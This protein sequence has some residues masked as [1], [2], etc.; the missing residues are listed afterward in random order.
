MPPAHGNLQKYTSPNPLQRYLLRRFLGRVG[1]VV[2]SLG[3]QAVLDAGCGEGFVLRELAGPSLHGLDLS[4]DALRLAREQAPRARL[5]AAHLYHLP[6]PDQAFPLVLC[7]EVLEHLFQP[8]Q[9]V[10]ELRRVTSGYLVASVPHEPWF[11]L[12][13]LLRAKNVTRWGSDP[14][15]LQHW[16]SGGFRRLLE[17]AFC[18]AEVQPVF[19]WLLG[20]A[21]K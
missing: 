5:V 18:R 15:H 7:L 8:E 16:G 12:A 14:E 2:G 1:A 9:A 13:N 19:P 21:R 10:A 3:P 11:R 4:P 17:R 6:Y 20:V